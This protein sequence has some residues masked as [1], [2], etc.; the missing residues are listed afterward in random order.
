MPVENPAWWT[1]DE[2][3][4]PP[5]IM[6]R[7]TL[8]YGPFDLDPCCRAETACAPRH[9][10]KDVDGLTQPWHGR[11]YVNPP[12]SDPTPWI[13]KAIAA[14][15]V[16]GTATRVVMLLPGAIDTAW[17]HDLVLPRA[18]I[19]FVRGRIRFLGWNGRPVGSPKQGNM[20]AIFPKSP[21]AF[22]LKDR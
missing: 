15:G 3:S 7:I 17:F 6:T 16:E 14:T 18:D 12:Y 20:L 22:S 5:D 13:T 1:S 9:F 21:L 8:A 2:W 19:V 11:V 4:T 10:T